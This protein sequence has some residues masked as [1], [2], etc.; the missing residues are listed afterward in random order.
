MFGVTSPWGAVLKDHNIRM[1]E[2][3]W[4]KDDSS[5]KHIA[6]IK[7]NS[8]AAWPHEQYQ[9]SLLIQREEPAHITEI[10]VQEFV[11]VSIYLHSSLALRHPV[12]QN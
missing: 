6:F 12:I 2:N 5:H 8:P 9:Q 10:H 1:A 3:H 11:S 7:W 4:F